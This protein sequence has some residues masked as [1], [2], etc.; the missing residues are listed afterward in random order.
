MTMAYQIK[1]AAYQSNLKARA[2]SVLSYLCDR[3]DNNTLTCFPSLKTIAKCLHIG[4][5]TVKR[6]MAELVEKGFV[7]KNP[8]FSE[9]KNGA[10][11]SNLYTLAIPEIPE[12]KP[13]EPV[14]IPEDTALEVLESVAIETVHEVEVVEKIAEVSTYQPRY[15]T[16][17]DM[18]A[19]VKCVKEAVPSVEE[20]CICEVHAVVEEV[21][22][23]STVS[24]VVENVTEVVRTVAHN[25]AR[26]VEGNNFERFLADKT[27]HSYSDVAL[28]L[29]EREADYFNS[30]D[31][32]EVQFDTAFNYSG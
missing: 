9:K 7:V 19:E 21:Q 2:V 10:Q 4:L 17:E 1:N 20:E 11:T 26:F 31:W 14:E 24:Q 29:E 18:R 6:A 25:V 13:V 5:S 3:S 12:K 32:G 15:V 30:V 16:F 27:I 28:E 23:S 22:A 8:R